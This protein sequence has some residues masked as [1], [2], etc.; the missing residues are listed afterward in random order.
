MQTVAANNFNMGLRSYYFSLALLG[1]VINPW[2][3]ILMSTGV[4]YV[5][6]QREFCSVTLRTLMV[7]IEPRRILESSYQQLIK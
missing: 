1:W 4:V 7:D 3:L 2:V 6:F 5:L